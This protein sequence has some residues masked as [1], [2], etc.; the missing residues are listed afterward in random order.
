[1]PGL[2]ILVTLGLYGLFA[3]FI[4]SWVARHVRNQV[5]R[6]VVGPVVF[7]FIFILPV[8]DEIL[9]IPHYRALCADAGKVTYTGAKVKAGLD[10]FLPDGSPGWVPRAVKPE[11][12]VKEADRARTAIAAQARYVRIPTVM[13]DVGWLIVVHRYENRFVSEGEGDLL[14]SY[15]TYASNGGWLARNSLGTGP[16][17]LPSGCGDFTTKEPREQIYK[18]ILKF[19]VPARGNT[20]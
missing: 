11:E 1:M 9:E 13:T 18:N 14:A 20:P 17:L 6:L 4:A 12:A 15:V 2:I 3:A 8:A 10:V 7:G 5:L 19:D 16:I